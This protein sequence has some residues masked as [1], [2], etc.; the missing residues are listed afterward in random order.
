ML[1]ALASCTLLG[2]ILR[3]DKKNEDKATVIGAVVGAAVG[4]VIAAKTEGEEV[5]I[6]AGTQ[7]S[8]QLTEPV[9]VAI[10]P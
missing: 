4:T 5:V 6:P 3:K 7:I 9:Q 10:T 8:L 1:T 2:K